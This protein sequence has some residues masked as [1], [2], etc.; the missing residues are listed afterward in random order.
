MPGPTPSQPGW[1]DDGDGHERWFDGNGW[2]D[3]VRGASGA[4]D[5]DH[6]DTAPIVGDSTVVVPQ[7]PAAAQGPGY[8]PGPAPDTAQLQQLQVG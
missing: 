3:H 1:Y 8:G 7:A 2:T 4:A 6:A 5:H